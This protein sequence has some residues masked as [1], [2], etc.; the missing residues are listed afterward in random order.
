MSE[1]SSFLIVLAALSL[2]LLAQGWAASPGT[3]DAL[4]HYLERA[5]SEGIIEKAMVPKLLQLAGSMNIVVQSGTADDV[6]KGLSQDLLEAGNPAEEGEGMFVHVYNRL[7]LLNVL[8]LSGAVIIMGAYTLFMMLAYEQCNHAML[9]FIM[10]VQLLVF[11]SFGMVLWRSADY[12]YAGG[13]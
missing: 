13:M 9:S 6:S 5:E 3:E 7:T 10:L 1:M 2:L 12:S 11:G 8:Y 4:Q